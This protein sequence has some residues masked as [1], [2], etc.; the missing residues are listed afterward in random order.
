MKKLF[1][2]A[3]ATIA[4]CMANVTIA[5]D[6]AADQKAAQAQYK[7]AVAK[8]KSDFDKAIAGCKKLAEDKQSPCYKEARQARRQA[9]D[10]ASDAYTNATGKPEPSPGA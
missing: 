10:A 4:A 2:V 6:M 5:A 7:T 8:A 3:A 1:I 9:R